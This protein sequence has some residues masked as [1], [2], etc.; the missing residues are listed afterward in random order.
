MFSGTPLPELSL[1]LHCIFM[2]VRMQRCRWWWA[3]A[4]TQ[5]TRGPRSLERG[6]R[7][8]VC[9]MAAVSNGRDP[10]IPEAAMRCGGAITMAL[11]DSNNK[12]EEM[13]LKSRIVRRTISEWVAWTTAEWIQHRRHVDDSSMI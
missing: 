2:V 10:K 9:S 12:Y 5:D 11:S 3:T 1:S 4:G 7:G 8:A 6:S 13:L